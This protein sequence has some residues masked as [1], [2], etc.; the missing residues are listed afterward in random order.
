MSWVRVRRAGVN[1]VD[2]HPSLGSGRAVAVAACADRV[3]DARDMTNRRRLLIVP[4]IAIVT[5]GLFAP[6]GRLVSGAGL[7]KA[8]LILEGLVLA[9]VAATGVRFTSLPNRPPRAA[10]CERLSARGAAW[11]LVGVTV[12]ALALRLVHLGDDLWVDEISTVRVYASGS[13]RHIFST[14][15]DPNNHLLN[16]LLVHVSIGVLGFREW[17]IRLPA[18]VF[19]VAT[20]PALYAAARLV[21]DRLR[22]VLAAGLLAVSY[23]HVFFSQNARGYAGYMLFGVLCTTFLA[24]ALRDDRLG[25][26]ASYVATALLCIASVPTGAFVIAGHLVVVAIALVSVHRRRGAFLPLARRLAAVYATLAALV[27]QLYAPVLADAG[28]VIEN[29]WKRPAAGFK[30]LTSGFVHQFGEGFTSGVGPLLLVVA[31]PVAIVGLLGAFS[32]TRRSWPLAIGLSLG[33]LLH[34]TVVIV[35]GLAFSPRFLLFLAFPAILALVETLRLLAAWLL[36][37]TARARW[38]TA[39]QVAGALLAGAILAAPLVHYY[40]VEKQPYRE[41]LARA[42]ELRPGGVVLAVDT[43]KQGAL[44]YG[45]EHPR[46]KPL[47]LGKTLFIVRSVAALDDALAASKGDPSVVLTTL[48]RVLRVGRPRLYQRIRR[49]WSPTETLPGSIGDGE[50]RIW[51]QKGQ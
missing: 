11:L 34:V 51:L 15:H 36:R 3:T 16:S 12:V 35:R 21:F 38:S 13:V 39:L 22:S 44:Y 50:I 14:Y 29:A 6:A 37:L 19:G 32:V 17:A 7:V 49:G 46:G 2:V 30:P 27:V 33:P 9:T 40:G 25:L 4:G 47:V 1:A 24:R 45:I 42:T 10:E 23:Q 20:V 5:A 31:V 8:I 18:L 48:D 41:A 26:W 28:G 43:M